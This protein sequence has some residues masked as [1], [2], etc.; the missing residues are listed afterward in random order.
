[1]VSTKSRFSSTTMISSSP[2]PAA[3]APM[4]SCTMTGSSGYTMPSLDPDSEPAQ[5]IV[6][7]PEQPQRIT[8]IEWVFRRRRCRSGRRGATTIR[9]IR[10]RRAYSSA[11]GTRSATRLRSIS[12]SD[13]PSSLPLGTCGLRPMSSGTSRSGCTRAVDAPS[14]TCAEILRAVQSPPARLISAA[15]M[16]KSRMSCESAGYRIGDVQVGQRHLR[17]RRHG[18]T[19]GTRVVADDR[20]RTAVGVG[21]HQVGVPDRVGRPVEAGCFAVPVAHDS[22]DA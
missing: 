20:D 15:C 14:A 11:R 7:D 22:L 19:L 1:M 8:D 21:A 5:V 17:R 9:L 6:A 10:L 2:R 13:A 4:N 3:V 18:G 16:P 12:M